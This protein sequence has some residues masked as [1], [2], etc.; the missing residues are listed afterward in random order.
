MARLFIFRIAQIV[1][2]PILLS[3]N[4]TNASTYEDDGYMAKAM[5]KGAT[6]AGELSKFIAAVT[7][8][9]WKRGYSDDDLRKIY[10]QNVMRTWKKAW[11]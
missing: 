7:D 2:I 9:L 6:G 3:A 10:G 1:I 8:E 11:K 5:D 4:T